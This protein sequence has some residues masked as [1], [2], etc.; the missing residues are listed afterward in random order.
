VLFNVWAKMVNKH[1]EKNRYVYCA[2]QRYYA[3]MKF[4]EKIP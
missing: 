1:N 3:T 2:V 4:G